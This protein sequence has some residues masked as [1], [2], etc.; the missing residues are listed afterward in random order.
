MNLTASLAGL[1]ASLALLFFGRGRD[2]E[3]HLIFRKFPWIVAQLFAMTVLWLF[4]GSLMGIA[5]SLNWLR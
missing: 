4:V 1:L 5:V 3:D 2:G